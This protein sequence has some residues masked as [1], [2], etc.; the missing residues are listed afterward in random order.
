MFITSDES[1][2][3]GGISRTPRELSGGTLP[4]MIHRD[5]P[6]PSFLV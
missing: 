2:N 5:G 6:S 3:V 4:F 1:F